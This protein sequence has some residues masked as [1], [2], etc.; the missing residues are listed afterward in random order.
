VIDLHCHILPALDDGPTD[1]EG[2]LELARAL[3]AAGIDRVA[4][5]PHIREDHPFDPRE[6][7]PRVESLNGELRG[8]G[9][10]LD[11]VPGG[12]V[13]L[14]MAPELTDD[15]L[16]ALCLGGGPYLLVE[17]PYTHATDLLERDL[18][19]L[20]VRGF[21]PIL[22]H[23]E[24]S[25]SF[26]S[27]RD[28][29]ADLVDRGMLCS[30]TASSMTGRFG[31]TVRRFTIDLF[32]AGL[33]HGVATDAHDPVSRVPDLLAGFRAV[34]ADLPG[35]LKASAWF[36]RDAPAAVLA[37]EEVTDPPRLRSGAGWMRLLRRRA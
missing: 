25:P 21:R 34:E 2:S 7:P 10:A 8:A 19:A 26:L 30:I 4:A 16:A 22:A 18:F 35:A 13:A 12:E 6:V 28:R 1:L 27:D 20:Q 24:R 9:V 32:R 3:V 37:G 15:V 5:T 14:S 17:S 36:T 23:P 33:V 31:R 11:V 29:L